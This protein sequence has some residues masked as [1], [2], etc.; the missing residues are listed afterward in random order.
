MER[1]YFCEQRI[2]RD[3]P[4][5]GTE[6]PRLS[7]RTIA[8]GPDARQSAQTTTGLSRRGRRRMHDV[9]GLRRRCGASGVRAVGGRQ[10]RRVR[11]CRREAALQHAPGQRDARRRSAL[12]RCVAADRRV[13]RAQR[14]ADRLPLLHHPVQRGVR[15]RRAVSRNG[16]R[17]LLASRAAPGVGIGDQLQPE[18]GGHVRRLPLDARDGAPPGTA[19]ARHDD[20][21]RPRRRRLQREPGDSRRNRARGGDKRPGRPAGTTASTISAT[22]RQDSRSWTPPAS[23]RSTRAWR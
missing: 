3:W 14:R 13:A 10:R 15:R 8:S 21:G 12:H 7:N 17:R 9:R 16:R 11:S 1:R 19:V 18:H 5:R 23:Y 22:K 6:Y 20:V 4:A 2:T